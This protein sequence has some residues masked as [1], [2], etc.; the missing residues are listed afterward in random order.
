M[1]STNA[2]SMRATS[3]LKAS[4]SFQQSNGRRSCNRKQLTTSALAF[5]TPSSSTASFL[6]PSSLVRS[7]SISLMT[8]SLDTSRLGCC[9]VCSRAVYENTGS[10]SRPAKGIRGASRFNDPAAY[11][12][13]AGAVADVTGT[14]P[15]SFT[16]A[17]RFSISARVCC[18]RSRRRCSS[19]LTRAWISSSS[20]L[21]RDESVCC[22]CLLDWMEGLFL[23]S[24]HIH[25]SELDWSAST[26]FEENWTGELLCFW[27]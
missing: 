5:S 9:R 13:G 24:V 1:R 7:C 18:S 21:A 22:S 25:T 20:D 16:S 26:R 10:C 19:S 14:A 6:L 11:P 15:V 12:A 8:E 2:S 23:L 3:R 27:G 4:T 17:R